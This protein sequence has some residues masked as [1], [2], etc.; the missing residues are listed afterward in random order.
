MPY[1]S[2]EKRFGLPTGFEGEAE[3]NS[4]STTPGLLFLR[5]AATNFKSKENALSHTKKN[6]RKI[7]QKGFGER[8][9]AEKD[10]QHHKKLP[11]PPFGD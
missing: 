3:W 8:V 10:T 2:G 11:V 1:Q 6:S 5:S 9:T 4:G 7:V